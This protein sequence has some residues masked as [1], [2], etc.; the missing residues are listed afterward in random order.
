MAHVITP[1]PPQFGGLSASDD[2]PTNVTVPMTS[3]S[4][5]IYTTV[6]HMPGPHS[7]EAPCFK[8]KKILKFLCEFELQAQSM[9]LMDAQCCEYLVSYCMEGEAK[10]VQTLPGYDLKL[11]DNLKD[12]LLSYYPTEDEEKVYQIKDLQC[13]IQ[14]D[15]KIKHH[16]DFDKY[17]QKFWII[18]MSLEAKNHLIEMEKDD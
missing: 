5:T 9:R 15:H 3:S 7:C 18:S 12:E 17:H 8:G 13:F 2:D 10:F 16:L 6:T 1:V 11:W 14:R 4:S